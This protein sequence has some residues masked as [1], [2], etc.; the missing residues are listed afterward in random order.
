MRPIVRDL[1]SQVDQ[2]PVLLPSQRIMQLFAMP[3]EKMAESMIIFETLAR[4]VAAR[5]VQLFTQ[6]RALSENLFT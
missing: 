2:T 3:I 1:A 6:E 4:P 5:S